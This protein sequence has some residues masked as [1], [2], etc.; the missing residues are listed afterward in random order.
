MNKR[1]Y[2]IIS[3]ALLTIS[4]LFFIPK[5]KKAQT[6]E[7]LVTIAPHKYFVER[8]MDHSVHVKNLVPQEADPHGFEP[9]AK[10]LIGLFSAKLWFLSGEPFEE[11]FIPIIKKNDPNLEIVDLKG[12]IE[13]LKVSCC[14]HHHGHDH[15][16]QPEDLHFW[17]SPKIAKMQCQKIA[18]KLKESFPEKSELID[19]KL[20][21]LNLDFDR[22]DAYLTNQLKDKEGSS[23][24]VSHPAFGYFAKQYHLHQLALENEGQDHSP[25]EFAELLTAIDDE[26]IKSLYVQKQYNYKASKQLAGSKNL[27]LVEVNPYAEN[28][29]ENLHDFGEHL[30]ADHD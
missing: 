1:L 9:S 4:S 7:V 26:Q 19:Q 10:E 13:T 11:Q 22:L 5:S 18:Y 15:H 12:N 17:M 30:G 21:E 24:L 25:R 2:F 23:F 16:H 14:H 28:Y 27:Q 6:P 3:L 8:L 20:I 29:F